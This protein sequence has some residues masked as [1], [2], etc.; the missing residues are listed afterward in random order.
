MCFLTILVLKP[1]NEPYTRTV[2]GQTFLS[3]DA[4]NKETLFEYACECINKIST[5]LSQQKLIEETQKCVEDGYEKYADEVQKIMEDHDNENPNSD[6]TSKQ[7]R[8][9]KVLTEN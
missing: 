7:N 5:E 1:R 2:I 8:L 9:R 3:C 6:L 4:Q